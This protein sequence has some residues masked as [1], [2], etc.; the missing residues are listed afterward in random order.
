MITTQIF[1]IGL[2]L[3]A[4]ADKSRIENV[5]E[6]TLE[7]P[8]D[9][10]IK[11]CVPNTADKGTKG[12]VKWT[13]S[14]TASLKTMGTKILFCTFEK[15]G[16][17]KMGSSPT[18]TYEV[19]AHS[20]YNV[21]NWKTASLA[22]NF[23]GL[24]CSNSDCQSTQVCND[25]TCV[26]KTNARDASKDGC[27]DSDAASE[28]TTLASLI[29]KDGYCSAYFTQ[30]MAKCDIG[31]GGCSSN[32]DCAI[33]VSYIVDST[34]SFYPLACRTDVGAQSGVCCPAEAQAEQCKAASDAWIAGRSD[35]DIKLALLDA[36]K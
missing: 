14:N 30:T 4:E 8:V 23:G 28:T 35:S 10:K 19:K 29:G 17:E 25:C 26:P 22:L 7:Y 5:N 24:C 15:L 36:R 20:V 16:D 33:D 13:D 11:D 9:F 21:S 1:N 6:V 32:E 27:K 34:G 3:E 31:R 18:K 12:I 2:R